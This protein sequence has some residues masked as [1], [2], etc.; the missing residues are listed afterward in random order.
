MLRKRFILLGMAIFLLSSVGFSQNRPRFSPDEDMNV[1]RQRN[2]AAMNRK[3][4]ER[5]G[6]KAT[7][8]QIENSGRGS[9]TI[10]QPNSAAPKG[11]VNVT[12]T[13]GKLW[14]DDSGYQLLLDET[15]TQYGITI[16]AEDGVFW[17]DCYAPDGYYD[18]FSHKIPT[19]AEPN[20]YT[21]NVVF[22]N[23]ITIQIPAGI[24]D[25]CFVNPEPGYILWIPGG[26]NGRR[27]DYQFQ[28]G[29]KYH[30]QALFNSNTG[31]DYINIT[32]EKDFSPDAPSAVTDFTVT[33]GAGGALNADLNWTNPMTTFGG[34]TLMEL[35]A[36]KVYQNNELIRTFSNPP[37][38][39]PR[40]HTAEVTASGV[41]NFEIIP[42]NSLGEGPGVT[43]SRYVG[44][45]V[46]GAPR[47][48]TLTTDGINGI[49]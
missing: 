43:V 45:D 28:E 27:N 42:E 41:Y 33:P 10:V 3:V 19:N 40:T 13:A 17:P 9:Y 35:T 31:N 30:F 8:S 20:C 2:D 48:V 11:M 34:E 46:P 12:L 4:V 26:S 25:F 36:V 1:L 38:G 24:Y 37:V 23:S 47:T 32:V 15:A 29:Y 16:P 44:I 39:V 14:D 5:S 22:Q 21:S 6:R 18:V 49:I 7:Q